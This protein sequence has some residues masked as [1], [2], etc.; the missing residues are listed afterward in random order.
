M[1]TVDTDRAAYLRGLRKAL[2]IASGCHPISRTPD[3]DYFDAPCN[4][5]ENIADEIERV[6]KGG[7]P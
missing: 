2:E 3:G 6:E 1:N 4:C 7:E 5:D